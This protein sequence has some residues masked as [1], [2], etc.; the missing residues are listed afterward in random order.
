MVLHVLT[1]AFAAQ[2]GGTGKSALA[3]H[4]AV[5]AIRKRKRVALIDLDPQ[6]SVLN[7]AKRRERAGR[8][9]DEALVVVGARAPEL[10]GLLARARAQHADLVLLDSGGRADVTAAHVMAAADVVLIPCRASPLDL[11]ASPETAAEVKR[12]GRRGF[13]V[14]NAVPPRGTRHE[15]ARE[16]LSA[17]LPVCPVEIRYRVSFIDALADGRSV[18]ELE[19]K[20]AAATEIRALYRWVVGL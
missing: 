18:E 10:G 6:G 2:K 9:K 16:A 15:E 14:L 8:T 4:L 11:D 20:G 5:C 13:F 3:I 17:L 19:P 7:W 12:T 1:I